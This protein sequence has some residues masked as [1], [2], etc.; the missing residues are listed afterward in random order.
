M[1]RPCR[2]LGLLLVVLS[3]AISA[4]GPAPETVAGFVTAVESTSLTEV[5]SFALR[6]TDGE[7][8]TFRVGAVE[9]DGGAFPA[10]HLRQH[11]ALAQ[12]VA[13]AFRME[14]GERVAFRLV[15]ATWL[16]P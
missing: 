7:E 13:V 11:M 6:T 10:N 9:L 3:F 14:D 4:C 2:L 16:Q 15:D 8:L 5:Q 1:I 12:G